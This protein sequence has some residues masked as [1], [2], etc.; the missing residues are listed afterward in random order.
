[1]LFRS[2]IVSG[3]VVDIVLRRT[4]QDNCVFLDPRTRL[5][6]VYAQRPLVCRTFICSPATKRAA[7]LR[8]LVVN[9]GEDELVRRW[10]SEQANQRGPR[11][12]DYP[13]SAFTG[14]NRYG[15][16]LLKEL[17]SPSLWHRLT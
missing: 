14:K 17:C 11:I 13:P 10:L 15:D 9:Q 3:P 4:R 6:T 2:V 1:M 12:E 7:Q 5:C 16:V 8:E